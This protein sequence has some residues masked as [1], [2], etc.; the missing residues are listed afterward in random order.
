MTDTDLKDFARTGSG[1]AFRR[2]AAR[3]G[4]MVYGVCLR[5]LGD[6]SDAEDASQAVFIALA[7]KAK[8]VRPDRLA[9]WLHGA[10]IRAA[11]VLA[12]TRATRARHEE[13]AAKMKETEAKGGGLSARERER[14]RGVLDAEVARLP[15]KAREAVVRH[16]FAGE[17]HAELARAL[18]VNESTVASRVGLG[19]SKLR[20]RLA[21]RGMT[22]GLAVLGPALL[23][24]A[25]TAAPPTLMASLPALASGS[26]AGGTVVGSGIGADLIAK[27]VLKMMFWAKVKLCAAALA[28]VAVVGTGTGVAL[29]SAHAG[30]TGPVG[31]IRK[32]KDAAGREWDLVDWAE[33]TRP[34]KKDLAERERAYLERW[35]EHWDGKPY[36]SRKMGNHIMSPGTWEH[37]EFALIKDG[38]KAAPK[39]CNK[40][41][42]DIL[43]YSGWSLSQVLAFAPGRGEEVT[44]VYAVTTFGIFHV[45]PETKEIISAG[46]VKPEIT[47]KRNR[48]GALYCLFL[49]DDLPTPKQLLTDGLDEKARMYPSRH[50][51]GNY[52]RMCPITGRV[53]FAQGAG[54]MKRM[55]PT[56]PMALRY[57]EKLLPYTLGGK[58]VL[59]PAFLDHGEMF[60]KVGAEPVMVDGKRAAPRLAVRTTPVRF[61]SLAGSSW[62]NSVVL[63]PDGKVFYGKAAGGGNDYVAAFGKTVHAFDIA[64]GEDL[65]GVPFAGK[66]PNPYTKHAGTCSRFDGRLYQNFHPGCPTGAGRLFSVNLATGKLQTLYDSLGA[67]PNTPPHAANHQVWLTE[68]GR[69]AFLEAY[70]ARNCDGPADATTLAFV[71]T[72]FQSQCP[73]TGAIIN[74]G[75]DQSGLRRYHGGFVTTLTTGRDGDDRPEWKGHGYVFR[76]GGLMIPPDIVPNGDL[77]LTDTW[78]RST[79]K[80]FK[81]DP[82]REA[83]IRIVRLR[84]TDWPAEQPVAGYWNQQISPEARE[85][86]MLEYAKKY[87]ANYAGLSKI[88]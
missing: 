46:N 86:L 87:I 19:L 47:V 77:Y 79:A 54:P 11:L 85:K 65:G 78:F 42:L 55:R 3:Y 56:G 49:Q 39:V 88:Y 20:A 6:A 22:L 83:A 8:V 34:Y 1:E 25:G 5:R 61:S 45:D 12:R 4:A 14:L 59:L 13:E 43:S 2:L 38:K 28:A 84:R 51:H 31:K 66:L 23:A 76:S 64:T 15:S 24:E 44:A 21:R 80:H 73:R 75:W 27:G 69:A 60:K 57:V 67:W 30:E 32:V 72:C 35:G 36:T 18:G 10:A 81:N 26:A 62:G 82:V 16:Y 50:R 9:A 17:S 70:R 53:Y 33:G 7:R 58:E 37:D 52:M 63:S 71:T 29:R 40:E 41:F 48:H 74:G 68:E